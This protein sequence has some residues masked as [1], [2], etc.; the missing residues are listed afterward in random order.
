MTGTV[1][2]YGGSSSNWASI[3]AAGPQSINAAG[4]IYS[5]NSVCVGNASGQCNSSG[6]TVIG[7]GN[8]SATNNI[9][10]SGS[11]F[12]NSGNVGIGTNNPTAKLDLGTSGVAKTYS[13]AGS[14]WGGST[15]TA[16]FRTAWNT[17]YGASF[18][19]WDGSAP[20]WGI[21]KWNANTP[22]V[23]MQGQ[24]DSTDVNFTGDVGIGTTNPTSRLQVN[25]LTNSEGIR[26]ISS[27]FSPFIIRN[28][29]D[30]NISD[31]QSFS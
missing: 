21:Y 18:E 25:P 23:V 31:L 30:H 1:T 9:P 20:K 14:G 19:A 24:Y 15:N 4:S 5:Y 11:V 17:G 3:N 13:S 16:G 28:S 12:V 29:A 22:A 6:G 2:A 10:N 26:I 27:N 7:L 8:T